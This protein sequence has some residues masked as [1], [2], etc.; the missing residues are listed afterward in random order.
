MNTMQTTSRTIL[1]AAL[2]GLLRAPAFS[3]QALVRPLVPA[4]LTGLGAPAVTAAPALG[5]GMTPTLAPAPGLTPAS[6]L[7]P[8]PA[9]SPL[10]GLQEALLTV[11]DLGKAEGASAYS[12]GLRLEDALTGSQSMG[13]GDA[14]APQD[15]ESRVKAHSAIVNKIRAEIGKVIVG[16]TEMIDAIIMGMIAGEHVLLE[17]VPGVAKTQTVKAFADATEGQYQRIQGTPDKLPSDILGAE[18]LQEDPA[19]GQKSIKLEKGPIFSNIL[20][21]D[22]INRMMPK[23]QSALLEAMQEGRVTIGRSSLELPKPFLLLA[24][25]NPIEQEG[26]YRLPE[27]QQDRF[28]FKVLVKRPSK[29]ELKEI[30]NRFSSK[31]NQPRASKVTDLDELAQARALADQIPVGA[32]VQQYIVDLIEATNN[33]DLPNL[34]L[35]GA[36]ENGASPRAAIF[37]MKAARIHAFLAGRAWVGPADVRAVATLIL[38]HRIMLTYQAGGLTADMVVERILDVVPVPRLKR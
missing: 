13:R 4:T 19:T 21:V 6:A 9:A 32:E 28:M 29:S 27:A 34:D 10:S 14:A 24:T 11:P 38:R 16:Q 18:I 7:A 20:L 35:K 25:Q 17:G 31:E 12:S 5:L 2:L 30:M 22:E 33:P 23:T 8:A 3:A 1:A 26:T 36:V 15:F 37:M